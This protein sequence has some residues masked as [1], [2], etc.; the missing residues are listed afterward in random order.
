M[1]PVADQRDTSLTYHKPGG[2]SVAVTT[3]VVELLFRNHSSTGW[4]CLL[5][6]FSPRSNVLIV[7]D[8]VLCRS[9]AR[10]SRSLILAFRGSENQRGDRG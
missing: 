2:D 7:G 1:S 6:C 5:V 8:V 10:D 9:H 4:F 3:S